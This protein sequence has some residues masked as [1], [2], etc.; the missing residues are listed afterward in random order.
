[1]KTISIIGS[2]GSIGRQ[3]LEVIAAYRDDLCVSGL[4]TNQNIDLLEQQIETFSP[5]AVAV[6]DEQAALT[7]AKRLKAKKSPV[8]VLWGEEGLIEIA[9]LPATDMLL[10]AVSGMIGLLPTLAAIAQKIDIALANKETLVAA[11]Q[12]VM[13]AARANQVAILPVDSEHSAIFQCLMGNRHSEIKRLIITA[14]GGPFRGKTLKQLQ[15][16]SLKE[17]LKHPNWAMGKK[18]SIDSATL[19]NK[20]LEVIEAKWLFNVKNEAIEV[21]VHP[22]SII[23]SMVEYIDH[24]TMAQLGMPDMKLPI[25]FAFFYPHRLENTLAPLDFQKIKTLTFEEPDLDSFP[26]LQL[27][28]DALEIGGSMPCVLNAANE[29]AVGRFLKEEIA[30]VDI[31]KINQK[32]MA[33]HLVIQEPD[34]EAIRAADSW[35][36]ERAL[37]L[38]FR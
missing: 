22:Q 17:A 29:I 34:L 23:H 31:A 35:A 8:Q 24:S 33:A 19:M 1:M 12:L 6:M 14:S 15:D 36:R 26:C 37:A 38:R 4:S 32:M 20:G 16:V 11:G 30:F 9:T 27:A 13:E 5:Q 7:L 18:I 28:Y 25:Q 21:V 10:T 2:T 3:A